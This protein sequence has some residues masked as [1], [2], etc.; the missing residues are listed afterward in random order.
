[1]PLFSQGSGEWRELFRS[2]PLALPAR[3]TSK[4]SRGKGCGSQ[5]LG[6]FCSQCFLK[7]RL[8][9]VFPASLEDSTPGDGDLPRQRAE[10][11]TRK[12]VRQF[13]PRQTRNVT[14]PALGGDLWLQPLTQKDS[15][16]SGIGHWLQ[17]LGR[18]LNLCGLL[19]PQVREPSCPQRDEPRTQ[20]HPLFL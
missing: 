16:S 5:G 17:A 12:Y 13:R 15:N 7:K 20:H 4:P 1:M 14:R 11:D 19:F 2:R 10:R 18:R 8:S 6:S 9:G 3:P